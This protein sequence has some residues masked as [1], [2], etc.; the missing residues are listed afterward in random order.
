[1]LNILSSIYTTLIDVIGNYYCL[2]AVTSIS[3]SLKLF[4]LFK[5]IIQKI[6][7]PKT[8]RV[9]LLLTLVLVGNVIANSTWI[10]SL[11]NA[12]FITNT[13]YLFIRFWIRIAWAFSIIQY[14]SFA[15]FL[16]Y[17]VE[18]QQPMKS[19]QKILTAISCIIILFFI[20]LAFIGLSYPPG[21]RF[22]IE[23]HLQFFTTL[24]TFFP[25]LLLSLVL[26]IRKLQTT[27]IPNILKKQL[28]ILITVLI[29]P[30]LISDFLQIFIYQYTPTSINYTLSSLSTALLT[31]AIYYCSHR[32][33]GL[34]FLNFQEKIVSSTHFNFIED[35]KEVL[36]QFSQVSSTRELNHLAQSF[37]KQAFGIPVGRAQLYL[38]NINVAQ[39]PKECANSLSNTE[40]IVENFISLHTTPCD[41]NTYIK[42]HKVLITDEIEFSNFYEESTVQVSI[43]S[44]LKNINADLFLP[45]WSKDQLVG[46]LIVERYA[47]IVPHNKK[48]EFYSNVEQDQMLVFASYLGNII[49]LL[50]SRNLTTLLRKEKELQDELYSKHQEIN[51]YKE[52]IRSFLRTTKNAA[53]GIIFYKNRKFTYGNQ[54]AQELIDVNLNNHE[55]HPTTQTLK[56]I[57]TQ[58]TNYKA[59]QTAFIQ[60]AQ[61]NKLVVSGLMSTEGTSVILTIHHPEISDLLKKQIEHLK[62]PSSW[63]YLL[64]LETTKSGQHIN[65]LIPGNGEQLLNFKIELLKIALSKKAILLD[66]PAHDLMGTVEIL[67]HISLRKTLHVLDLKSTCT[68]T[69]IAVKLFGMNPIFGMQQQEKP[70]LEQL[71][72]TGTL[73]IKNVQFLDMETQE[74]L[75]E[76]I[77]YGIYRVFKSEKKQSSNLR[78][79][80]SCN[81]NLE[82]LAAEGLFSSN[83]F[84]ELK[85]TTLTMPSLTSLSEEELNGLIAGLAQ[86][87]MKSQEFTNLLE[88]SVQEKKKLAE[89]RPASLH[90]LRN[91]I[92]QLLIHKS[93]ENN[94][95][96]E[97]QFDPAYEITDPELVEA[98]RLGK[99]ALKDQKIMVM[100]WNKFKNQN[101]IAALLGVNRSSVNRRCKEYSLE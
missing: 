33:I 38:R 59:P 96:Q 8:P 30:Y 6:N 92:Q 54:T 79:I 24:Y 98:A 46:Y 45:V 82:S 56:K 19:Y 91:K 13:E 66:M 61:G 44:F 76:F 58:V 84:H 43:V 41:V 29:V 72:E 94:I 74:Y 48:G 90:E 89:S 67:H 42:Q 31:L 27:T 53:I 86:Q 60:D 65:Q 47:R 78:V 1:M 73:F 55:G 36:E 87:A 37:F 97:A 49:H 25:M 52:S 20:A 77:R 85:R 57:V 51:Q 101:K 26:T 21:K 7:H 99:Y 5:L 62:D 14:Q 81:K 34:R 4:I 63:D 15:L 93:K 95:H 35:F 88:L 32:M 39:K 16:E 11:M 69:E 28:Q 23:N 3:F 10:I 75:A 12:L 2:L 71:N 40:T 18:K 50:H 9:I 64:Y 17:L 22:E 83:L 70:L 80:V 68:T 100:L